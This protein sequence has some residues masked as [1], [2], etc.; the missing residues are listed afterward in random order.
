MKEFE[1]AGAYYYDAYDLGLE[2]DVEF[3]VEEAKTRGGPVLE[4]A[5]GTGRILLPLLE[6]GLEVDG[7]DR[8]PEMLAIAEQKL[9]EREPELQSRVMLH[10]GDMSN[11]KLDKRYP[12]IIIPHRSFMHLLTAEKQIDA[13]MT[14]REHLTEDGCLIFN[15]VTPTIEEIAGHLT[16]SGEAIKMDDAFIFP[17]TGNQVMCWNSRRYYP[18]MQQ[19]EQYFIFD[20]IN[21]VGRMINRAYTPLFVRYTHRFEMLHLLSLCGFTLENLYGDFE[22]GNYR[23]G[24]EQ[25]WVVKKGG[26]KSL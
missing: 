10:T 7:L 17:E 16:P 22:K 23:Y 25:I 18:E 20:E 2:G 8:S 9:V 13:L 11:F 12:L 6:A 1:G 21:K 15:I 4:L 14:I 3:Y 5:C 24:C 19:I 26:H